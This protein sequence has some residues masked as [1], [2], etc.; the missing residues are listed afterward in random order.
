M[1]IYIYTH[2]LNDNGDVMKMKC[3]YKSEI[4][5][6]MN[7]QR[8][9]YVYKYV[10]KTNIHKRASFTENQRH[11]E[12]GQT[13]FFYYWQTYDSGVFLMKHQY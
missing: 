11:R 8:I 6:P 5:V 3:K 13:I 1:C 12:R 7:W 9:S 2:N 4:Q 10:Y